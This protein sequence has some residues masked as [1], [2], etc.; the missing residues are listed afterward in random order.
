MSKKTYSVYLDEVTH[1]D[2]S[3]H[4]MRSLDAKGTLND[5]V[6]FI[7]ERACK[8]LAKPISP[9][10]Q[11]AI[12]A[13]DAYLGLP[14][15]ALV[16]PLDEYR[17]RWEALAA[18][19]PWH[20]DNPV[21]SHMLALYSLTDRPVAW[22]NET[23]KRVANRDKGLN[24]TLKKIRGSASKRTVRIGS[25]VWRRG[26]VDI[27]KS[28]T[29]AP[30]SFYLEPDPH[31]FVAKMFANR[32]LFA[33]I[34]ETLKHAFW[35]EDLWLDI[36]PELTLLELGPRSL[37]SSKLSKDLQNVAREVV[38]AYEE[39]VVPD[40]APRP[41]FEES[42]MRGMD[43]LDRPR[44]QG[45]PLYD[46]LQEAPEVQLLRLGKHLDVLDPQHLD[47]LPQRLILAF[48]KHYQVT[49]LT[50]NRALLEKILQTK[51]PS[52]A[53]TI[54]ASEFHILEMY[55]HYA[56]TVLKT[57]LESPE[58]SLS[59][60]VTMGQP[61]ALR[62]KSILER[63]STARVSITPT[64]TY[65]LTKSRHKPVE[66][67]PD[68]AVTLAETLHE[69][70][71]VDDTPLGGGFLI[72]GLLQRTWDGLPGNSSDPVSFPIGIDLI[73]RALA[74]LKA[75]KWNS[76][77]AAALLALNLLDHAHQGGGA[78]AHQLEGQDSFQ[79][80]LHAAQIAEPPALDQPA[81]SKARSTERGTT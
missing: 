37:G 72:W 26:R 49:I 55:R 18:Q 1:S 70:I 9:T 2:V 38:D 63:F 71:A 44:W 41:S 13:F 58:T 42:F 35:N 25:P 16:K 57:T 81:P 21:A 62:T 64:G 69:L 61:W 40:D 78:I 36:V 28:T 76:Q 47:E 54:A 31:E 20:K 51:T 43:V 52:N 6:G 67:D 34:E 68:T 32:N 45:A 23:D 80:R 11:S 30:V 4:V 65:R 7:E 79:W 12:E 10:P 27:I 24:A 17:Q 60:L 39:V 50:P 59:V 29:S 46:T 74:V 15:G 66:L 3:G 48:L 53:E 22:I 14:P 5:F 77:R 33:F 73:E 8:Q 56:A 19:L 75:N